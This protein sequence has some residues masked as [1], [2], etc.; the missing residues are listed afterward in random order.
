MYQQKE[1]NHTVLQI[2]VF[3]TTFNAVDVAFFC[4]YINEIE[5]ARK[6]VY[7]CYSLPVSSIHN[8][9]L[10]KTIKHF[11]KQIIS[12][13]TGLAYTKCVTKRFPHLESIS[14]FLVI[15][16]GFGLMISA[17]L[18]LYFIWKQGKGVQIVINTN[19]IGFVRTENGEKP[20][21]F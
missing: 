4:S 2:T 11:S 18:P 12:I 6:I 1:K 17:I 21:I 20:S 13:W 16:L 19:Y 8:A 10:S 3:Y 14:S 9:V 5:C 15:G 7:F